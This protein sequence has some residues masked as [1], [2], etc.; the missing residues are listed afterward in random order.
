VFRSKHRLISQSEVA[1][2][3]QNCIDI[4]EWAKDK[5][6]LQKIGL[7]QCTNICEAQFGIMMGA[8]LDYSMSVVDSG[9]ILGIV[10]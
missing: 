2:T 4:T 3:F 9:S 1:E 10:S 6:Q 8:L 7:G 5:A